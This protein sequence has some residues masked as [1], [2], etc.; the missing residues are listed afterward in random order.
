M[1]FLVDPPLLFASGESYARLAPEE[2][3]G[4]AAVVAGAACLALFWG[5]GT[6]LY[7]N[8]P[9]TRPLRPLLPNRDGRDFMVNFPLLRVDTRKPSRRMNVAAAAI[10]G[11]VYP[12]ALWLG[13]DHGRRRRAR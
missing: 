1:S 10:F 12:L 4:G 5:V 7:L 13:W 11:S 9:P 8:A 3:Q 6:A 2:A